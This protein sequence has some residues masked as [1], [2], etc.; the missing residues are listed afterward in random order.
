MEDANAHCLTF[1]EWVENLLDTNIESVSMA[2]D[3][4]NIGKSSATHC[5]ARNVGVNDRPVGIN[6]T[7]CYTLLRL[8]NHAFII[9]PLSHLFANERLTGPKKY[10]CL[11]CSVLGS[12]HPY[13]ITTSPQPYG[14]VNVSR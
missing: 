3:V 12:R 13:L 14:R 1:G 9:L 4:V 5:H 8:C 2:L 10:I 7:S 11:P 6:I